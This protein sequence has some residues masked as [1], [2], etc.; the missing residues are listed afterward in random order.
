MMQTGICVFSNAK[1]RISLIIDVCFN[2]FYVVLLT[3]SRKCVLISTLF[4]NF[5]N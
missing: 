2:F 5:A 3:F 4:T 1:L